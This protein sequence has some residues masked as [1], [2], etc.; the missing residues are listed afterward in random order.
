MA[1]SPRIALIHATPVAVEPINTAFKRL[2]PL[3]ETTD[4]LDDSLAAGSCRLTTT[5][6]VN[7]CVILPRWKS[8]AG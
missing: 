2:W 4:L 5:R 7:E 3:A 8:A 1:Q 6:G